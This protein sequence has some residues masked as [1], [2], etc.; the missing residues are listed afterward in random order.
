MEIKV[1]FGSTYAYR[2]V[3]SIGQKHWKISAIYRNQKLLTIMPSLILKPNDVIIIIGKPDVLTQVYSAISKTSTQFPMPFGQN[4]YLYIDM[5]ILK[6]KE[7]LD[8]IRSAKLIHQRMKNKILVIKITKPTTAEMVKTIEAK[9]NNC[10]NIVLEMDYHNLGMHNI[11]Q[12]DIAKYDIGMIILSQTIFKYKE[13][14]KD[15]IL[16]KLPIFKLGNETISSL[17]NSL[18]LLN[19][20]NLYEQIAPM[21]FDISNQLKVTPKILNIDPI[22]DKNTKDLVSHLNNLSKIFS[23]NIVVI[24]EDQ[25]PIKRI[26]KENLLIGF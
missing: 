5:F 13:A 1:P 24:N 17:K 11:L 12:A 22:G 23:Q 10:E 15:I 21:L 7:I 6:E 8:A 18:I 20:S 9:T 26:R 3:G 14:I 4:I 16:L 19:E 25:N 2:Y